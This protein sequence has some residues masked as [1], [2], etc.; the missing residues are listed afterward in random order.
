MKTAGLGIVSL[1]GSPRNSA[2]QCHEVPLD[3][4]PP[5][6]GVSQCPHRR[7]KPVGKEDFVF[8]FMIYQQFQHVST[9]D[10]SEFL[11]V[12]CTYRVVI[13]SNFVNKSLKLDNKPAH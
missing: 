6:S 2:I 5:G 7:H 4:W 10:L 11:V 12:F 8:F 9:I 13:F 3:L 1:T